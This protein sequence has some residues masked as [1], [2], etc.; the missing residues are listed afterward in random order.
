MANAEAV[1]EIQGYDNA[2]IQDVLGETGVDQ[3][4]VEISESDYE[5]IRNRAAFIA[6]NRN[7][8]VAVKMLLSAA[9]IDRKKHLNQLTD[10]VIK[11]MPNDTL[12]GY[13]YAETGENLNDESLEGLRRSDLGIED[14]VRDRLVVQERSAGEFDV[15]VDKE[16]TVISRGTTPEEALRNAQSENEQ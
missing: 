5:A 6:K 9:F 12:R 14:W 2:D 13:I 7:A 10:E 4:G 16:G 11:G 15:A 1:R 8:P 3:L